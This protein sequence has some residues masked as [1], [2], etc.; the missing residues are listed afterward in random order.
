MKLLEV[1]DVGISETSRE[2]DQHA[3]PSTRITQPPFEIA[4]AAISIAK[5]DL[6]EAGYLPQ[7]GRLHG[8]YSAAEGKPSPPRRMIWLASGVNSA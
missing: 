7:Q 4:D 8:L 2:H 3:R 6:V 1:E 5:A